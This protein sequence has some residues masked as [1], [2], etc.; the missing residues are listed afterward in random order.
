[1]QAHRSVIQFNVSRGTLRHVKQEGR[2]QVLQGRIKGHRKTDCS[3]CGAELDTRGPY[4]RAC[5]SEYVGE[6]AK[7]DRQELKEYRRLYGP[8]KGATT[9]EILPEEE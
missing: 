6:R 9:L 2:V 8:L 1:V 7:R 3:T 4:C 5:R